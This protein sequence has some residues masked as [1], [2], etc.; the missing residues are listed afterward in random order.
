MKFFF[1]IIAC[2]ALISFT[3]CKQKSADSDE[4]TLVMAEVN[5]SDTVVGRMDTAFK[6][7]VEELSDGKIKIDLQFAGILGDEKQVMNLVMSPHSSIQIVRGPANLSSYSSGKKLKSSLLSIPYT[8]K[9]DEHFWKFANS[10]LA[11]KILEEPYEMGLGIKGLFYCEEGLRHYFSTA[12][13]ESIDDLKGKKMRVSKGILT[14]LAKAFEA[15][16]VEVNFTDLYASFQ[17]G[18][19]EV[20]EQPI[21][22]YLSNSFHQV[23]P[24]LILDG[25]MTGAVSVMINSDCW[26]S[27]SKNQKEILIEAGK[28]AQDYCKKIVDEANELASVI[29]KSEGVE[30]VEV[31]DNAAWQRKCAPIRKEAALVD[32]VLYQEILDLSK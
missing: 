9:N 23:A 7:K 26:D 15:E 19:V 13:I 1:Y 17:M 2:S 6:E 24:H 32:P 25:H 4:I 14:S 20:A 12:K 18:K 5:P 8:F 22:N 10:E 16:P 21:T 30:I 31:S 27:L 28:Y 11:G 29:L 3:S